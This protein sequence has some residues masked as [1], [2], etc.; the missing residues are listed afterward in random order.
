MTVDELLEQHPEWRDLPICVMD[1][2]GQLHYLDA[3]GN[4]FDF[5]DEGE[6]VLV[7]VAN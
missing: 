2:T 6:R 4:V 1:S 7:F 3:S 5:I